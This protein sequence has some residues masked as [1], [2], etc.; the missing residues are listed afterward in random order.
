MPRLFVNLNPERAP[1]PGILTLAR[2]DGLYFGRVIHAEVD[3]YTPPRARRPPPYEHSHYHVILVTSGK[4]AF[5]IDGKLWP[6]KP[7]AIFFSAPGQSH[8]FLNA[9]ND[10]TRYA[11]VT[12]EFVK[13]GGKTLDVDFHVLLSEW[14]KQPCEPVISRLL[15]PPAA[16]VLA[17]GIAALVDRGRAEPR[18]DDLELGVL[19]AEILIFAFREVFLDAAPPPDKIDRARE[20][21]RSRYK[22]ALDVPTLA[23]EVGLSPAHLSRRFKARFGRAPID[24]QLDLRL[25]AACELLRTRPEP[26]SIIAAAVGFEDVYYFSRLFSRR[27]GQAPGEF[28]RVARRSGA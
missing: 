28:R 3:H 20:I 5:E 23:K 2:P 19:L 22:E 9:G 15:A 24:Y 12:F 8:Q 27:L 4:G 14:T 6:T 16:R 26:L 11:E 17:S 10:T 13:S 21:I 18:P 7:G 25:R 1:L